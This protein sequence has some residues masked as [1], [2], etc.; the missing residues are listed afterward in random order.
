MQA[1]SRLPAAPARLRRAAPL[2]LVA[3]GF[4]LAACGGG[5][6][7]P[8]AADEAPPAALGDPDAAAT[9]AARAPTPDAAQATAI[10]GA[11]AV[12]TLSPDDPLFRYLETGQRSLE[13][14]GV[15]PEP[16]EAAP[17][18][19]VPIV[20]WEDLYALDLESGEVPPDLAALDGQAVK[21]AGFMVPLDDMA[22]TAAEFL[23]VPYAGACIHVPPPPANQIVHVM[24]GEGKGSKVYWWD[25]VWAYGTLRIDDTEHAYGK[26]SFLMLGDR[27][28]VYAVGN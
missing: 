5:S 6:G 8:S 22:E 3:L 20:T 23:L 19:G 4:L 27:T 9:L 17:D 28:E 12:A 24:M 21:I 15:P 7:A 16:A 1:P 13:D 10:A 2:P 25:P 18:D 26:A 14:A 11:A